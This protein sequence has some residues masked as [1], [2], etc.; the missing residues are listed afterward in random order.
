VPANL[1]K[2]H[3]LLIETRLLLCYT[4]YGILYHELCTKGVDRDAGPRYAQASKQDNCAPLPCTESPPGGM[5][6]VP[7]RVAAFA[8]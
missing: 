3:I 5:V 1:L 4:H 7:F 6:S 2:H 8:F